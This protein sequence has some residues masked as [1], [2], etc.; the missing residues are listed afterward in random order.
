MFLN[1]W[2]N[3]S[4]RAILNSLFKQ[5]IQKHLMHINP[6]DVLMPVILPITFLSFYPYDFIEPL[7][8]LYKVNAMIFPFL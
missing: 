3:A 1:D 8:Y 6:A 7:D 5:M 4:K 2:M